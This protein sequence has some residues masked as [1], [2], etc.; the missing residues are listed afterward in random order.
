MQEQPQTWKIQKY[1][2]IWF[3]SNILWVTLKAE[4]KRW[5]QIFGTYTLPLF[6]GSIVSFVLCLHPEIFYFLKAS[7]LSTFR[8]DDMEIN[9]ITILKAEILVS[10]SDLL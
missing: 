7:S 4:I 5:K 8:Q 1:P 10:Q 9:Q 2:F 6:W 3:A